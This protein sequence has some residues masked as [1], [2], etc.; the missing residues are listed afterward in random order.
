MSIIHTSH[1]GAP[2]FSRDT[3]LSEKPNQQ[4]YA[5]V[6]PMRVGHNQ[7]AVSSEHKL[8]PAAC[9]GTFKPQPFQTLHQFA[10]R[11]MRETRH[12]AWY[13][14]RQVDSDLAQSG[15]R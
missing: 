9:V 15:D 3:G 10:T 7:P 13:L 5:H 1:R 12:S 8:V 6:F 2:F 14:L 11:H 4:V